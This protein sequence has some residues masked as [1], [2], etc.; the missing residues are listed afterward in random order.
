L[1]MNDKRCL[2]LC[3]EGCF[4]SERNTRRLLSIDIYMPL[5]VWEPRSAFVPA[6]P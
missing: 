4:E 5:T 2:C 6:I 3:V 1:I